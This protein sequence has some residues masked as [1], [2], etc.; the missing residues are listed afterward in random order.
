MGE[1]KKVDAL[2]LVGRSNATAEKNGLAEERSLSRVR[3]DYGLV[4]NLF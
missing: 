4:M 2:V 1:K 3:Y